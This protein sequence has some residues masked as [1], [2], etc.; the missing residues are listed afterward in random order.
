MATMVNRKPI[1]RST[2]NGSGAAYSINNWMIYIYALGFLNLQLS[3][4]LL[5]AWKFPA[6]SIFL[7]SAIIFSFLWSNMVRGKNNR[8]LEYGPLVLVVSLVAVVTT[9]AS[10]YTYRYAPNFVSD[11][12]FSGF[13]YF[14]FVSLSVFFL[15]Y[16]ARSRY[17][18]F[19]VKYLVDAFFLAA[20]SFAVLQ[21][22]LLTA[23]IFNPLGDVAPQIKGEAVFSKLMGWSNSRQMLPVS[24]AFQSGGAIPLALCIISVANFFSARKL[25]LSFIG[26]VCGLYLLILLDVQQF[27]ISVILASLAISVLKSDR[28]FAIA[29]ILFPWFYV[30]FAAF[31][32][33]IFPSLL[34]IA[35][36]RG[37]NRFGL[38][39]G[40]EFIW[41]RFWEYTLRA[42]PVQ[43]IFG[44][45]TY[46]QGVSRLSSSYA[47]MFGSFPPESRYLAHLHNSYLQVI[48]D[49]GLFGLALYTAMIGLAA[50]KARTL[51]RNPGPNASAWRTLGMMVAGVAFAGASEVAFTI[52][53]KEA[54]VFTVFAMTTIAMCG[55]EDVL[56]T[57]GMARA[58]VVGGLQRPGTSHRRRPQA[59]LHS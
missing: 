33:Y 35:N 37:N 14:L 32:R 41:E 22:F 16:D 54:L 19:A 48:V 29:C 51:S 47:V 56:H 36:S 30:T 3:A 26:M 2:K 18:R 49:N 13:V 20:L 58:R 34:E 24:S 59:K 28:I 50:Y 8:N 45:G 4:G 38:F 15:V 43:L 25:V 31:G 52:Y 21:I 42:D 6:I 12:A 11:P 10:Y 17:G 39:T 5:A 7:F 40:R 27:L 9:F 23:S 44:N 57:A 53:M 1:K 55:G 46:G